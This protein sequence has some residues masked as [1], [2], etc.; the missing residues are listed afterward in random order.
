MLSILN[1]QLRLRVPHQPK[2]LTK[3][4]HSCP[5]KLPVYDALADQLA[6]CTTLP[7]LIQIHAQ[8]ISI[9]FFES[10]VSPIHWNNLIRSYTRANDPRSAVQV[11][12][13]MSRAGVSPDC[14]TLP[15]ILKAICQ[16]YS[17]QTATQLHALMVHRGLEVHEFC[18]SALISLY[19]KAGEFG[20][21]YKVFEEN[22]D[23]KLGSWNAIVGGLS[24]GG[25]ARDAIDVFLR[26][27][28]SGFMPDD[29]T[30]V[31]VMVACGSLRDLNF[32]LQLHKCVFQAMN[33]VK[34]NVLML[35]SLIDA[36]GKCGRMDLASR[37]FSR[38]DR[39]NVSSWTSMIVGYAMHGCAHDALQYFH[40]MRAS[41]V[42]PNHVTF[43]GVLSACVHGVMVQEG[44]NYFQ[45]MMSFYGIEPQIQHFGCMVDL[46]GR[47]GLLEEA[48]TVVEEMP[49]QANVVI[50]GS[51]LGACERYSDVKM[52]EWVAHHLLELQPSNDAIYVV[53]SNI[54][55]STN[56]W[57]EA[58][59]IRELMKQRRLAKAPGSSC[60]I[61]S[62]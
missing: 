3:A 9:N 32:A 39:R 51:L 37:I 15:I 6:R 34:D 29:V 26:M 30:M 1:L 31:G 54:Y 10:H 44:K 41:S 14:Y 57:E 59:R 48:R 35:N 23:R 56:M 46:L 7:K 20:D 36:Y 5:V 45:M 12:L 19:C 22:T 42:M 58:G 16:C 50:W 17:I 13:A 11:Y 38:M 24:Q 53:L 21:A 8:I 52:G 55:A 49:M 25:R 60:P 4:R 18:E 47:A 33:P 27:K 2:R 28:R 40:N 62:D 43:L 61:T